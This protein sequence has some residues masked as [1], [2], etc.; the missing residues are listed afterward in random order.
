LLPEN[1]NP[2][3]KQFKAQKKYLEFAREHVNLVKLCRILLVIG[4]ETFRKNGVSILV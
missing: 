2:S 1:S 4:I 3:C